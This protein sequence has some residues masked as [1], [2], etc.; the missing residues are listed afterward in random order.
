MD[1]LNTSWGPEVIA[2]VVA[3]GIGLLIGI[4]RRSP[5]PSA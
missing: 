2:T 1:F 5:V 3:L 4:E